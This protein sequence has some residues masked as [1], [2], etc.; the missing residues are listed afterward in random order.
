MS[1]AVVLM[2]RS[3]MLDIS[4]VVKTDE[5]SWLRREA[6]VCRFPSERSGAMSAL[7][8][9]DEGQEFLAVGIFLHHI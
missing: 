8:H 3:G 1:G 7:S 9:F 5:S 4:L 2:P 6:L